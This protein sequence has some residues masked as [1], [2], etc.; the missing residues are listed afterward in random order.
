MPAHNERVETFLN[1]LLGLE[2]ERQELVFRFFTDNLDE[3]L[4]AA[5]VGYTR[6]LKSHASAAKGSGLH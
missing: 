5:K 6:S 1:R 2:V 4:K 3:V